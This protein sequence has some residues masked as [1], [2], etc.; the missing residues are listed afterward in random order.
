AT[1][2]STIETPQGA[3]VVIPTTGP[4]YVRLLARN[5]SGT[6]SDPTAVEGPKG[7]TPVVASDVLDGIITTIK[8]ADDAVTGAKVAAGAIDTEAIA[9]AA[10]TAAQIA[11][12]AVITAAIAP[13]AVT[14]TKIADG[15]ITTP[16]LVANAVTANELNAAAVTAAKIAA[17]AVVAGKLDASSVVAGNIAAAAVQAGNLAAASVQAGNLA[18]DS[19]QAGNIA[20]D[21]ITSRE[22]QALSVVAGK[23]AANAVTAT[24]ISAGAITTAKLAAGS[25]DATALKADAITGKTIT[26]GTITGTDISGVTV[27]GATVTGGTLQTGTTGTRVVITPSPPAGIATRPSILVYS[28]VTGELIPAIINAGQDPDNPSIARPQVVLASPRIST[29]PGGSSPGAN[30]VLRAPKLGSLGG[31]FILNAYSP[32]DTSTIGKCKIIGTGAATDATDSEIHFILV[33]GDEVASD[34]YMFGSYTEFFINGSSHI[35][36]ASGLSLTGGLTVTTTATGPNGTYNEEGTWSTASGGAGVTFSQWVQSTNSTYQ[37]LRLSKG[38]VRARLDGVAMVATAFSTGSQTAF[39][40][41]SGYR[42]L[43]AH[44]FAIPNITSS[45]PGVL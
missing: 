12:N 45:S 42:P 26:G 35:L 9:A 29:E 38:A 22:L 43:K 25:V 19:V 17:G 2:Q 44:Y 1:L 28:G 36:N 23:I 27:T 13:D 32:D 11:A 41:P 24:E 30:L 8:I 16:K 33:D 15:S 18:A 40:I 5:T 20:A 39:T 14:A 4:L 34:I 3:T 37:T 7:P 6:A 10:I 21:V 31:A